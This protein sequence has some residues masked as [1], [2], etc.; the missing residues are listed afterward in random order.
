MPEQSQYNLILKKLVDNK[1][2]SQQMIDE[3]VEEEKKTGKNIFK[4]LVDHEYIKEDV[5]LGAMA[6]WLSIELI[7][8]SKVNIQREAINKI[9][10]ST[11]KFYNIMPL[12]IEG[13]AVVVAVSDPLNMKLADDLRFVTGLNI[14]MVVAKEIDI[15]KAVEHYYGEEEESLGDVINEAEK[16]SGKTSVKEEGDVDKL[17]EIAS[18]APVVKLLNMVLLRAIRE[19]ASD[20]HFE[21]FEKEYKIRYRIDGACYDAAH[22]PRDL[23]LAISSRI[24]V[25]ANL[26]VAEHR[27]PQDGRIIM[28]IG[29]RSVDLRV[30][31]LPT[32]YGESIVMRVLDK[33]VVSLSLDQLGMSEDVKLSLRKLIQRPNGI[34]LTTG[35]TG[36]GKTT[37]LYSCLREINKI[38][39]KIITVEDPVEY[40]IEGIIQV[41]INPK[42]DLSF[43]RTLRHILRQDPDII[44]VG[45]IR[46]SETA[47]IA[48][49]AALTGHLVFSTL[50]TNDAP[51]AVA[52]LTDMGVEPFLISSTVRAVIAQRLVRLVCQKCKKPYEPQKHEISELNISSDKIKDVELYKGKGCSECNGSGYK[53]R[54]G[55]YELFI[56]DD[57]IRELVVRRASLAAI[58]EAAREGGM[59]TLREDAI[60]KIL[61]GTTTVEEALRETKEYG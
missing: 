28:D 54:S 33:S 40:D 19:K 5:L 25:M 52:R 34:L 37:T 1:L 48:I 24:K 56:M 20:I 44:M 45:E 8:I 21:P 57:K 47:E 27:L 50:H 16:A 15:K 61:E 12:K 17:K 51:G 10:A 53:G 23:S 7:D 31:T 4:I 13:R 26:D 46:D 59:K 43:A 3:A 29:G 60:S 42:I 36:S 41:A 38:D 14:K 55:I 39:Y 30:S 11:A 22:P 49:Q 6:D 35:P 32:L 58:R 2:L 9:S 18:Q